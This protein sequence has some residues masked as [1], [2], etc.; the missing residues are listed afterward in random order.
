MAKNK[1][2]IGFESFS[3]NFYYQNSRVTAIYTADLDRLRA[4]MPP[5]ILA[6]VQPLQVWPG[7]GL[8]RVYCVHLRAL[9]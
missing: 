5:E 8:D 1:V 3:P 9:R 2:D 6:T 4:L 7:R